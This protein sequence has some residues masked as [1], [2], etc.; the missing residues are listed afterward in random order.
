MSE[1]LA[2]VVPTYREPN[3]SDTIEAIYDQTLPA[4]DVI[5]VNND[6][7]DE[8]VINPE[9][10]ADNS[11]HIINEFKKGTGTASNTGFRYAIDILNADIVCRTDADTVPNKK[12]VES[13][14]IGRASCRERG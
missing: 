2:I 1:R 6:S 12:W 10:V 11:L 8:L 5:V 4:H 3:L 9:V 7:E 14:Q 13:I